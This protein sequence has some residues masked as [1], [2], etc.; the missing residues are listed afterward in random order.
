MIR[1]YKIDL[2]PSNIKAIK[3]RI[4]NSKK[5]INPTKYHNLIQITVLTLL[6][7]I[8]MHSLTHQVL[9]KK[10]KNLF[11]KVLTKKNLEIQ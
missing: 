10:I 8:T 1:R 11:K 4:I 7:Q 6:L 2:K 9:A 5:I 3:N